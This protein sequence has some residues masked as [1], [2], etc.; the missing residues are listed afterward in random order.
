MSKASFTPSADRRNVVPDSD[1]SATAIL[2]APGRLLPQ[3]LFLHHCGTRRILSD[4]THLAETISAGAIV[5]DDLAVSHSP[6]FSDT[7]YKA[8]TEDWPLRCESRHHLD[9]KLAAKAVAL[10]LH[11]ASR[12]GLETPVAGVPGLRPLIADVTAWS[13]FGI[14]IAFECGSTDGRSILNHLGG[15][16][17]WVVALP[18][19]ALNSSWPG[20]RGYVFRAAGTTP[21]PPVSTARML[22][23][24][25]LL[26]ALAGARALSTCTP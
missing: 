19:R 7:D 24:Q 12:L 11:P 20:L 16:Y 8:L 9:L 6:V 15:G 22:H 3:A 26:L 18:F 2:T 17:G 5:V 13:P 1:I 21:L 4:A 14:G 10:A 25:D 23:A